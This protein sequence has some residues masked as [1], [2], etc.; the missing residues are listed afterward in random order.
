MVYEKLQGPPTVEKAENSYAQVVQRIT[1]IKESR[2]IKI[3]KKPPAV[4][5]RPKVKEK[6]KS[7]DEVKMVLQNTYCPSNRRKIYW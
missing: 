6:Y 7:M 4:T 2:K 1:G 3:S 5:I